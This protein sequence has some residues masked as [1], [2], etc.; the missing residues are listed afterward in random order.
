MKEPEFKFHVDSS[1]DG[2]TLNI[3]KLKFV[4]N[5]RTRLQ[6]QFD[7][8]AGAYTLF[9]DLVDQWMNNFFNG[10]VVDEKQQ[11][12]SEETIKHDQ[13]VIRINL[14]LTMIAR[15]LNIDLEKADKDLMKQLGDLLDK[16]EVS[17]N[18]SAH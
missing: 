16:I 9:G 5:D 10:H 7:Y 14:V 6:D 4:P 17:A 2:K 3:T 12:V 13:K 8:I 11:K 18:E 15:I 1:K